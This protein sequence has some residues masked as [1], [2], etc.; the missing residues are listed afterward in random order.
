MSLPNVA[1]HAFAHFYHQDLANAHT[2]CSP[3]RFS[4]ITFRL[5]EALAEWDESIGHQPA[6]SVRHVLDH[7]GQ[8][9]EDRGRQ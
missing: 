5:A 7:R 8:Y 9:T 2:H 3:V 4:P 6:E 1:Y